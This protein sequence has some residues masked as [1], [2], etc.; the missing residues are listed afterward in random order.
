MRDLGVRLLAGM[1]A[2]TMIAGCS[3]TGQVHAI[4][5]APADRGTKVGDH[6]AGAF[7]ILSVDEQVLPGGGTR[8]TYRVRNLRDRRNFKVLLRL[9]RV[10]PETGQVV[11]SVD[12]GSDY[13]HHSEEVDFSF[14]VAPQGGTAGTQPLRSRLVITP[15]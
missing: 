14:D 5:T 12:G 13:V 9:D 7:E 3:G 1:L 15:Q 6:V 4:P 2:V 8:V 10:V 11:D